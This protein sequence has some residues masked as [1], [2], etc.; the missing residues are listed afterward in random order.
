MHT[1]I[2]FESLPQIC[3]EPLKYMHTV[4]ARTK[5]VACVAVGPVTSTPAPRPSPTPGDPYH[6]LYAALQRI[7]GVRLA[8]QRAQPEATA[9]CLLDGWVPAMPVPHPVIRRL[10]LDMENA[11]L[12]DTGITSH[13]MLYLRG[14]P[15]DSFERILEANADAD[16]CPVALGDLLGMHERLDDVARGC[17]PLGPF[18]VVARHVVHTPPYCDDNPVAAGAVGR[19][20]LAAI[21]T[22]V[23]E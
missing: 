10:V 14:C 8:V 12:A 18:P 2:S 7:V 21:L 4:L 11:A 19:R 5:R 6:E 20:A 22:A 17:A 23:A 3:T 1:L 13:A 9:V 16:G 15:H